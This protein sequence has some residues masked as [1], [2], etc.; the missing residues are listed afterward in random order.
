MRGRET[1]ECPPIC[2]ARLFSPHCL[3]CSRTSC[4]SCSLKQRTQFQSRLI[5]KF[6]PR[7]L[8]LLSSLYPHLSQLFPTASLVLL[9]PNRLTSYPNSLCII[10]RII[11]RRSMNSRPEYNALRQKAPALQSTLLP[12]VSLSSLAALLL[13]GNK[14]QP[15]FIYIPLA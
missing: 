9:L 15:H 10:C 4:R 3:V 14:A 6:V 5:S 11:E 13:P 2:P 7:E 8:H 12:A 1:A